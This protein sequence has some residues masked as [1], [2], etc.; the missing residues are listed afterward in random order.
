MRRSRC[1]APPGGDLRPRAEA[2][3]PRPPSS[4][5]A[6]EHSAHTASIFKGGVAE[7]ASHKP[8]SAEAASPAL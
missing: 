1:R 8:T 4:R 3:I 7:V 2:R 5:A 6:A